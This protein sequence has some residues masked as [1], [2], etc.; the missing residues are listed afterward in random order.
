MRLPPRAPRTKKKGPK[1]PPPPNPAY[2]G[3]FKF[4]STTFG[5]SYIAPMAPGTV[6][7]LVGLGVW[8]VLG[9]IALQPFLHFAI[10]LFL[11][12]FATGVC[13]FAEP[14]WGDSEASIMSIDMF[15]GITIAAAPF[16]PNYHPKWIHMMVAVVAIYWLLSLLRPPPLGH[17][18]GLPH[19]LGR[20]VD[21][22]L[23]A[24]ATIILTW[25]LYD[26]VWVP[27]LGLQAVS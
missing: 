24:V 18:Q 17:V 3:M 12:L 16:Q 21:D 5:A 1:K 27:M 26:A 8:W 19:G 11:W 7:M 4:L 20:T 14:Y 23:A 10:L 9:K 25:G 6:G 15:S 2:E 13:K 22:L